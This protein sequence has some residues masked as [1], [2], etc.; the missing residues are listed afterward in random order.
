V[1]EGSKA[2]C[3]HLRVKV[4]EVIIQDNSLQY[5]TASVRKITNNHGTGA[6]APVMN[7]EV[8]GVKNIAGLSQSHHNNRSRG[9]L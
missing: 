1:S 4:M 9:N 5:L 6:E 7:S 3:R 8:F 2:D